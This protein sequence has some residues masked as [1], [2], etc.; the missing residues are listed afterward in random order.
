MLEII[1]VTTPRHI[2]S[3][4]IG[5]VASIAQESN[6]DAVVVNMSGG[7]AHTGT[8]TEFAPLLSALGIAIIGYRADA[9]RIVEQPAPPRP[10]FVEA[11]PHLRAQHV[12]V[13]GQMFQAATARGLNTEN[14]D[15][16]I[17]AICATLEIEIDSRRQLTIDEMHLVIIYLKNG[18]LTWPA[19][20]PRRELR[21]VA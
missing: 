5:Q 9:V 11:Y 16:M 18:S 7:A 15:G 19:N 10:A 21:R 20:A 2:I 4:N 14:R 1:T 12:N 3:L 17:A 8:K 13:Q 6:V